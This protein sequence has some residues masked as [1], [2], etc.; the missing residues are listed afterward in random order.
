MF[1][2]RGKHL[3]FCHLKWAQNVCALPD[4]LAAFNKTINIDFQHHFTSIYV[5][6]RSINSGLCD[7]SSRNFSL[8]C[9]WC[10]P[11]CAHL[12]PRLSTCLRRAIITALPFIEYYTQQT[13]SCKY[14]TSFVSIVP[15]WILTLK[16]VYVHLSLVIM[17]CK[18]CGC[19]ALK[20]RH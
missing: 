1:K 16:Y 12:I 19:K 20:T 17:L 6:P 9:R 15:F 18:Q 8:Y 14:K 11:W 4:T 5:H 10:I 13:L 3:H 2:W 7:F